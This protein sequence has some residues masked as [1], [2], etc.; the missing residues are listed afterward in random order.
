[1]AHFLKSSSNLDLPSGR[2]IQMGQEDNLFICS[3]LFLDGKV[4]SW[5][6]R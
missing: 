1:M 2:I 4:S 3:T 5:D 6:N